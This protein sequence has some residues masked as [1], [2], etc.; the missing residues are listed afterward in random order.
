MA[1]VCYVCGKRPVTGNNVSHA[2]NK[3]RRRWLPNLR[4]VKIALDSGEARRVRVC[5]RCISAGKVRKAM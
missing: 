3:S 4:R 1:R 5:T 2:N